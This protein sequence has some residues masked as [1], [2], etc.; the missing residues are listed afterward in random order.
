M[1]AL[2]GP[3]ERDDRTPP[4]NA[5][6]PGRTSTQDVIACPFC[7]EANDLFLEPSLQTDTQTFDEECVVCGKD[8]QITAEYDPSG[9]VRIHA[10]RDE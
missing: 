3:D 7:G 2:L 8:F 5:T 6:V 10:V 1:T 9:I 4:D